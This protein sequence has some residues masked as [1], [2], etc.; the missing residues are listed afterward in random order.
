MDRNSVIA[1]YFLYRRRK[2]RRNRLHWVHPEILKKGRI[3]SLLYTI[4]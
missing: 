4:W 1:L 3:R 2:R